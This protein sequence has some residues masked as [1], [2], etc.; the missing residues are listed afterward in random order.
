ML[1]TPIAILFLVWKIVTRLMID[2]LI[3][4][5]EYID[6]IKPIFMS[7]VKIINWKHLSAAY[8][9]QD[10]SAKDKQG[11]RLFQSKITIDVQCQDLSR[12]ML[13]SY[14]PDIYWNPHSSVFEEIYAP[15]QYSTPSKKRTYKVAEDKS[16]YSDDPKELIESIIAQLEKK[17]IDI[18]S[19]YADLIKVGFALCTIFG[20]GGRNYYHRIGRMYSQYTREETDKTY[21]QLLSKNN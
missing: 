2:K 18:T 8:E 13:L 6:H 11:H 9:G 12:S 21:T 15:V 10:F 5:A 3:P 14:D 7:L 1:L 19:S 16:G 20:E 17:N 4:K